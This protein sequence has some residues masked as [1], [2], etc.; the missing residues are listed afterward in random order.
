MLLYLD[1]L[2]FQQREPPS[3]RQAGSQSP[4]SLQIYSN[5]PG[6]PVPDVELIA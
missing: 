4:E 5:E 2:N 6:F 3:S 1:F